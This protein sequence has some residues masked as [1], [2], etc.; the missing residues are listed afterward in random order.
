VANY[1]RELRAMNWHYE[2]MPAFEVF[3]SQMLAP[4]AD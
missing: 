1:A 3:C 4:P 2:R